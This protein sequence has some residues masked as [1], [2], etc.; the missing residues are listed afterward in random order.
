MLQFHPLPFTTNIT[1]FNIT[2]LFGTNSNRT[3]VNPSSLPCSNRM[4]NR[5]R[6]GDMQLVGV[7]ARGAF[8]CLVTELIP[9]GTLR[10]MLKKREEPL[11]LPRVVSMALDI[12][13]GMAYLHSKGIILR[14]LKSENLLLSKE[15]TVKICDL[16]SS[17]SDHQNAIR[18]CH[19]GEVGT[20]RW[21]A[22]EVQ[23]FLPFLPFSSLMSHMLQTAF[24]VLLQQSHSP[25]LPRHPVCKTVSPK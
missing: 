10:D 1:M 3:S 16:G 19:T 22:P 14:D 6:P 18:E 7:C 12:A 23:P 8:K 24:A 4:P 13:R 25:L 15:G 5:N 9:D 21:M 2:F 20:L 11:P 17:K